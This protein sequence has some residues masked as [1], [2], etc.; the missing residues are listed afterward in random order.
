MA[1]AEPRQRKKTDN[2]ETRASRAKY[3]TGSLVA[4]IAPNARPPGE[5]LARPYFTIT[6]PNCASTPTVLPLAE[7]ASQ[8][9]VA[10]L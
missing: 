10:G 1:L 5:P 8:R 9:R 2:F 6:S 4:Q 3:T 7:A